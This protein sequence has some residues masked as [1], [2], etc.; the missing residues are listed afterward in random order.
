LEF[1]RGGIETAERPNAVLRKAV[2]VYLN[3]K[4]HFSSEQ[5]SLQFTHI[6]SSLCPISESRSF[7]GRFVY[8]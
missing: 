3:K 2:T 6:L 7:R 1:K 8:S 5:H 4:G